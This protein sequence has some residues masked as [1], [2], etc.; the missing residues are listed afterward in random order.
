MDLSDFDIDFHTPPEDDVAS[1]RNVRTTTGAAASA[2]RVIS[3][4]P[5]SRHPSPIS[6]GNVS[7]WTNTE[8]VSNWGSSYGSSAGGGIGSLGS[9]YGSGKKTK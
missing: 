2:A 9:I 8:A 6:P 3:V 7:G 4:G 1:I 5:P